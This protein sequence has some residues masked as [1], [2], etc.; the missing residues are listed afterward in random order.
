MLCL[1]IRL[2]T[3]GRRAGLRRLMLRH[4]FACNCQFAICIRMRGNGGLCGLSP[5]VEVR[6][7][8]LHVAQGQLC[9][10]VGLPGLVCANLVGHRRGMR[11]FRTHQ[12]LCLLRNHIGVIQLCQ[13]PLGKVAV[14]QRLT[15]I[16]DGDP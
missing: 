11:L 8:A 16:A 15:Q 6:Q 1:A 13:S 3:F 7:L 4:V 10:L 14:H 12:K 9:Y 2:I 5:S